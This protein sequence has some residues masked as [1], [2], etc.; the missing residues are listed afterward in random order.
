MSKNKS[1][2]QK[3][4]N[5]LREEIEWFPRVDLEMCIGCGICVLG[6]GPKVY[7]F[8]FEEKKAIVVAPYKCKVGCVTCAN[9]C[10]AYAISFPPLSYLHKIIKINKVISVSKKELGSHRGEY[11][12]KQ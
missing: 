9:T 12:L 10:P 7:E 3:W 2:K 5:I 1:E 8:N 6:C 4:H 11:T